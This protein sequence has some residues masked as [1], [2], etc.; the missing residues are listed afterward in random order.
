[1]TTRELRDPTDAHHFLTQGLWWQRVVPT[2]AVSLT[3]I[4]DWSLALASEGTPLPPL[5]FI[6]DVGHIIFR[7]VS[8]TSI[9]GVHPPGWP[10]ALMRGYEDYVLGKLLADSGLER[11]A[12]ALSRYQG[13]DRARGLAFLLAQMRQRADLPGVLISPGAIKAVRDADTEE[14]LRAGWQS[15][16]EQGPMPLLVEM[17]GGL[18]GAI[19]NTASP[20]GKEDIFELERKTALAQFGQRVA[21][22]QVLQAAE[23]LQES[24][25]PRKPRSSSRRHE[26]PTRILEEDTYPVGG[27][28]SISTRGSIESL[29][30]S[31][32][33]FMEETDRPDLFDIKF[34]RDELLYYSR[35]ENSFLRRRRTFVFALFPEL[36]QARVK[37]VELT[38]QRGIFTLALL[39][40]AVPRLID[41]LHTDSLVFEFILIEGKE[42]LPLAAEKELVE[43]LLAEQIA[44]GT[45]TIKV[46]AAEKLAAHCELRARRS[47]CHC[48]LASVKEQPLYA[49]GA[50]VSRLI[51]DAP[52]PALGIDDAPLEQT[53]SWAAALER[54]LT[55]WI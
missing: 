44:N 36:T 23:S 5:G 10:T 21:L 26:V 52:L 55:H 42:T 13:R 7:A 28:A 54:L 33:A 38:F 50:V 11:A 8:E 20:V 46:L 40:A 32:L 25:P 39:Y 51:V 41:W 29:L 1:M 22:R 19:R 24:L 14:T 15:F 27:F 34:L 12:D 6:A 37:D 30:H 43:V 16:T 4:L 3:Q 2:R 18:V 49:E 48:L 35:D 17:Y 47:L 9:D 45:V 31:Q 53:E